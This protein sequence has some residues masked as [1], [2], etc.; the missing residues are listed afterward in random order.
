MSNTQHKQIQRD[1][2]TLYPVVNR[3]PYEQRKELKLVDGD[4]EPCDSL[5]MPARNVHA[6]W[7]GEK[8]CPK[9]GEWYLSGGRFS[10]FY[11]YLAPNDLCDEYHIAVLVKTKTE[12][13]TTTTEVKD[14]K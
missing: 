2:N 1:L 11:A 4:G 8:R 6:K 14:S 5:A 10:G 9:K 13:I 7:T 3:V 12:T